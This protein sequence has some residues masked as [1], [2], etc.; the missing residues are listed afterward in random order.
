MVLVEGLKPAGKDLMREGLIRGIESIHE[1]APAEIEL[2]FEETQRVR[3][4][5]SHGR[6]R[7]PRRTLHRLVHRRAEVIFALILQV[8]CS[9]C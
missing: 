1:L 3:P 8:H 9:T 4:R 5:H 7:R 2:F 6:S